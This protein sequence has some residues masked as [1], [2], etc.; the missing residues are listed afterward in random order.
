MKRI[1]AES[2]DA[3]RVMQSISIYGKIENKRTIED[4]RKGLNRGNN[5]KLPSLR[6]EKSSQG[7]WRK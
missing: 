7:I 5:N 1:F 3:V 6:F 2:A 4:G